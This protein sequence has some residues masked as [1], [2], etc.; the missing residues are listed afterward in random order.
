[1][2]I[3]AMAKKA[4]MITELQSGAASCVWTAGLTAVSAGQLEAFARL[5]AEEEREACAARAAGAIDAELET[6]EGESLRG[7][8]MAAVMRSN[9]GVTGA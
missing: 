2:Y 8:V 7:H 3:E 9:A 4:G 6:A 5:V 1:M